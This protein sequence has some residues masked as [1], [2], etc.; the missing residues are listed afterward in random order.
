MSLSSI[1]LFIVV[2]ILI[3]YVYNG[4][5]F[6]SSTVENEEIESN[7]QNNL[8]E[9]NTL[10]EQNNLNGQNKPDERQIE[11]IRAAFKAPGETLF[12]GPQKIVQKYSSSVNNV[13]SEYLKWETDITKMKSLCLD[14]IK[15][16]EYYLVNP[17]QTKAIEIAEYLIQKL[18]KN[19]KEKNDEA[20]RKTNWWEFSVRM[21]R[22]FAMYVYIGNKEHIKT[23]CYQQVIGLIPKVGTTLDK[24][25]NGAYLL[26]TT[27]P[28]LCVNYV[29]DLPTFES[30]ITSDEFTK[31]KNFLNLSLINGDDIKD[32]FY[33]DGSLLINGAVNYRPLMDVQD[34]CY[35]VYTAFDF[36]SNIKEIA[37]VVLPKLT[38]PSISSFPL[39]LLGDNYNRT[40]K[41]YWKFETKKSEISLMPFIGL[42]IFKCDKFITYVRV[43]RPGIAAYLT[44][45]TPKAELA[46]G[47]VQLRRIYHQGDKYATLDDKTMINEPGLLTFDGDT[48][49]NKLTVS[50]NKNP[51]SY[52]CQEINSYV[53]RLDGLLFWKNSYNFKEVYGGDVI[54][55]EAGV[56]TEHGMQAYYIINNTCG[57][58]LKFCWKDDVH[59]FE[60]N[61]VDPPVLEKFVKVPSRNED[62]S[63]RWNMML[64]NDT[65]K[66]E[67][68]S[69]G[70]MSFQF[71][72][73]NDKYTIKVTTANEQYVVERDG[74]EAFI[75]TSSSIINGTT[76]CLVGTEMRE[77][78]RNPDT[79]MYDIK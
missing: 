2:I 60:N 24:T 59:T 16:L 35:T 78:R 40:A 50:G 42:G 54:V 44:D 33:A 58:T 73:M 32:G 14:T 25:M 38:H 21:T 26:F 47:S 7:D 1:I 51:K 28:R 69:A 63:F 65:Y 67:L 6:T 75:G 52:H 49:L 27:V 71:G 79:L 15:L 61:A 39:G 29:H 34:V 4:F 3:V 53:G 11:K 55:K 13:E 46:A 74:K 36:K 9:Q 64:T 76:R 70:N 41:K 37:S 57:K 48:P 20:Y 22:L 31:L 56:V 8:N 18:I 66:V 77:Y 68:D 23:E 45:S 5:N 19:L 30:D 12:T 43:Q 62:T 72:P 10:N 17:N